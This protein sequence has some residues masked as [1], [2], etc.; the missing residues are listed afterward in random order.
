MLLGNSPGGTGVMRVIAVHF[1]DCRQRFV[2]IAES[3]QAC[4]SGEKSAETG[5]LGDHRPAKSKIADAAV[6]EPAAVASAKT[7][8]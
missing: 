1:V 6:A 8:R 7:V 3:E 2:R 4:T 5:L